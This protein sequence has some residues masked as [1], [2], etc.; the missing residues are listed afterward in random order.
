MSNEPNPRSVLRA[1][2]EANAEALSALHHAELMLQKANDLHCSLIARRTEEFGNLDA[3]IATARAKN[4]KQALVSDD[5][6]HLL[7][8]PA[9]G[10]AA[11]LLARGN[12]DDQIQG[13]ADSIPTLEQ[14]LEEARQAAIMADYRFG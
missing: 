6:G 3:E 9:D 14:E 4:I 13:V 10:F 7:T 1:A 2:I 12:L 5:D 8:K 11:K